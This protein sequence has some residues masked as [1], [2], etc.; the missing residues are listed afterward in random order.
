MNEIIAG[1]GCFV[2][3]FVFFAVMCAMA[4]AKKADEDM[5]IDE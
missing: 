4:M 1:G 3:G 5:G 2:V